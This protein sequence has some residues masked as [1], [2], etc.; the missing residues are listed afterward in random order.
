MTAK[1]TCFTTFRRTA[2][3]H[4]FHFRFTSQDSAVAML[5]LSLGLIG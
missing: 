1:P 3:L 4:A 2:Q 5:R